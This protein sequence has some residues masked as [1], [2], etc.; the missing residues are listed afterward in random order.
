[1]LLASNIITEIGKDHRDWNLPAGL[2]LA[3]DHK[4]S[5]KDDL[6]DSA[7]GIQI[8]SFQTAALKS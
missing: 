2:C 1:M 4:N 6:P 8:T 3:C 7:G 5:A